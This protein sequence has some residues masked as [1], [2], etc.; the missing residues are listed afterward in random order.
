[1]ALRGDDRREARRLVVAVGEL[2]HAAAVPDE[3]ITVMLQRAEVLH[4]VQEGRSGDLRVGGIADVGDGAYQ[5]GGRA[6]APLA[7]VDE[8]GLPAS[9]RESL[10]AQRSRQARADDDRVAQG[11]TRRRGRAFAHTGKHLALAPEPVALLDPESRPAE[12]GAHAAGHGPGRERRARGGQPGQLAN[13]FRRPHLGISGGRESV[14]EQRVGVRLELRQQLARI[15]G[16]QGELDSP[17]VKLQAVETG[18]RRRPHR[19]QR[20]RERP[21]LLERGKGRGKV[22]GGEGVALHGDEVQL[23]RAARIGA[24]SVPGG[25]KIEPEPEA[26]LEDGERVA[27]APALRQRVSREEHVARLGQPAFD[28]VVDVLELRRVRHAF[29]RALE[30]CGGDADGSAAHGGMIPPGSAS[31]RA[32]RSRKGPGWPST[33]ATRWR[34]EEPSPR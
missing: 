10:R 14:E 33:I 13:D 12:S 27:P 16:H 32:L 34:Q 7:H 17:R 3:V 5:A 18:E 20:G 21:Q 19:Q 9:R 11:T 6:R 24:Q 1:M 31:P 2:Q 22:A 30:R 28:A 26:R 29:G 8:F 15:P 23:R 25:E 4:C